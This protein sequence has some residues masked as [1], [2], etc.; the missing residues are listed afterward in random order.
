MGIVMLWYWEL[1]RHSVSKAV[2]NYIWLTPVPVRY[3]ISLFR[4]FK[5][6]PY[7]IVSGI[8]SFFTYWKKRQE[9]KKS[10]HIV[11]WMHKIF[12]LPP[13]LYHSGSLNNYCIRIFEI[14]LSVTDWN[15]YNMNAAGTSQNKPH[16]VYY[17]L[18]LYL[19]QYKMT[20]INYTKWRL[21]LPVLITKDKC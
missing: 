18:L 17:I 7:W 12:L 19:Q 20:T 14:N 3:F 9:V 6:R 21:S 2:K 16:W 8:L 15:T 10:D 1:T 11:H 5:S 4:S 13:H